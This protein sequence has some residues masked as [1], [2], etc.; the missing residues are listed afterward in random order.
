VNKKIPRIIIAAASSDSGKTTITMGLIRSFILMGIEVFPFKI[1]PDYLD[2]GFLSFCAGRP[3]YNLDPVL[4]GE[5]GLFESLIKHSDPDG[6]AV[7]EGVMGLYDG[8]KGKAAPGSTAEAARLTGS[9]VIV[10]IDAC[11]IAQTAGAIALG[12][13]HSK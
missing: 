5:N 10:I 11:A 1:G 13:H 6:I 7:I 9:P 8:K 3:C 12:H 4:M 2:P